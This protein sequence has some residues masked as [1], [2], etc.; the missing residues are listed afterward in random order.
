MSVTPRYYRISPRFWSDPDVQRWSDDA[1]LLAFYLLTCEHRTTEGLFVLKKK[2]AQADLEWDKERFGKAFG[3]LLET[4]FA[5]YDEEA[6]VCLIVNALKYQPPQNENQAKYAVKQLLALPAT[7][8]TCIFKQLVERFSE[9][10]AKQLPE[11]FGEG[12]AN[13]LS[14]LALAPSLAPPPSPESPEPLGGAEA[15]AKSKVQDVMFAL[16]REGFLGSDLTQ[17]LRELESELLTNPGRLTSEVAWT[18]SRA[19]QV[20]KARLREEASK[21]NGEPDPDCEH[22]SPM[23]EDCREENKQRVAEML[24]S[25]GGEA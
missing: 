17:P 4:G 16:L 24:E 18:R 11:G 8:L 9:H 15:K 22:G 20:R 1:K 7:P 25:I 3:E 6:Q 21:A 14:S 10:L 23:C 12:Y 19:D 13:P 5:H 2:Y